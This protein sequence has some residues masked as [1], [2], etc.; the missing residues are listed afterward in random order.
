MKTP[1]I[2]RAALVALF[3]TLSLGACKK[4]ADPEPQASIVFWTKRDLIK[5]L[6]VD[7]YVDGQ[8]VGTLSK[9][10]MAKVACGDAGSPNSKVA[11]GRHTLE[12]RTADGQVVKGDL[13][14]VANGC[15]TFELT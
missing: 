2:F 12:F 4:E 9:V 11:L 3:F 10:S 7:C 15:H 8:L 1:Q 14:A 13:D 5:T 6:K